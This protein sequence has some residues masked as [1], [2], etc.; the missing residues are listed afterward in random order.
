MPFI[1]TL[2]VNVDKSKQNNQN[3]DTLHFETAI[4]RVLHERS[5]DTASFTENLKLQEKL[6]LAD[7]LWMNCNKWKKTR[8]RTFWNLYKIEAATLAMLQE[9]SN[10]TASFAEHLKFQEKSTFADALWITCS[11]LKSKN[12]NQ[13]TIHF[14]IATYR[15]LHER[16]NSSGYF[17]EH[18]KF[19][20]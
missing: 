2:L 15:V 13:D 16:S 19:W 8:I 18:L 1:Q 12:K 20:D 17:V 3:P 10:K 14:E 5:I 9:R 6:T 4:Y 11:K 7:A